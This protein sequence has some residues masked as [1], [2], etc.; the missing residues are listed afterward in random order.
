MKRLLKSAART[1]ADGLARA[2]G[3]GESPETEQGRALVAELRQSIA[4]LPPLPAAAPGE[5]ED[6]W[7]VNLRDLRRMV[8][9]HDPRSFLQ[10]DVIRRTM[11]ISNSAI[12]LNEWREIRNSADRDR[13]IATLREDPVGYPMPF[14]FSPR[15]SGNQ[16]NHTYHLW[17]FHQHTHCDPAAAR[18]IFE[19]GGGYGSLCRQV[20]RM[21]FKGRYVIFDLPEFACLQRYFF[22]SIGLQILTADQWLERGHGILLVTDVAELQRVLPQAATAAAANA[23]PRLV[24]AT[25]S[26]SEMPAPLRERLLPLVDDFEWFLIGYQVRFG[27][28]ENADFFSSWADARANRIRWYNQPISFMPHNFYLLGA[29]E[30]DRQRRTAA[31]AATG[32]ATHP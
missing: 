14:L 27:S 6:Q 23:A 16:I 20:H 12:A 21:G 18:L 3:P 1:V 15:T 9:D 32:A 26:L 11:F 22:K 24:I 13:W 31:V 29:A 8:Q 5:A 17:R 25:W 4:S 2:L 19:I 28:V 7:I 10:W 30:A